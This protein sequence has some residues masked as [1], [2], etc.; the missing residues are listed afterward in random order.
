MCICADANVQHILDFIY[1][2]QKTYI[3]YE[4]HFKSLDSVF[5]TQNPHPSRFAE[6]C[7]PHA[8]VFLNI[9]CKLTS[10]QFARARNIYIHLRDVV[11]AASATTFTTRIGTGTNVGQAQKQNEKK[12]S[13]TCSR[14]GRIH[15][16]QSFAYALS[17]NP[18]RQRANGN[19]TAQALMLVAR[20]RVLRKVG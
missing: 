6:R 19:P 15:L 18:D 11:T 9:K 1:L 17:A 5:S 3:S 2:R 7:F 20:V 4:E 10:A 8:S 12:A 14:T 16:G 13:R